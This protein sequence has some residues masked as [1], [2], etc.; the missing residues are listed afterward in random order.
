VTRA[1]R[2]AALD[3]VL[4][5]EGQYIGLIDDKLAAVGD[6]VEAVI[7]DMLRKAGA[8]KHE[9]ITLYY[10]DEISEADA[11]SLTESLSADFADQEFQVVNGGQPLYP[12]IISVE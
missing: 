9:L 6:T 8:D 3:G 4:A 1:V 2:D 5:R 7:R 11:Q 10:G 12:Y